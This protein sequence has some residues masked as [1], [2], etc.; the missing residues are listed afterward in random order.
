LA[1]SELKGNYFWPEFKEIR[2]DKA[3][4]YTSYLEPGEY[5]IDYF[6]RATTKGEFTQLP[7]IVSEMYE[8]EV[9][10]RTAS[11]IIKIH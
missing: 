3:F 8:P 6:L 10:G 9:F 4:I 2:D 5:T 1:Q 7:A 11:E